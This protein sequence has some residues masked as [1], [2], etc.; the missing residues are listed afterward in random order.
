MVDRERVGVLERA[1]AVVGTE[2]SPE[3]ARLLATLA[4][5]FSQGGD[6]E[7]RLALSDEAVGCARRI[8]DEVTL[9][10]VLLHTTEA[11]RLPSTLDQRLI[12]TE[13]LFS[14]AKR[15][16]DPVL[17][18]V[19]AVRE[20]R[21]KIEA[22]AFDQVDEALTVLDEVAHIDPYVNNQRPSLLAVLAHVRGEFHAALGLADE[23]RVATGTDPDALPI[24][25]ATT[26]QVLWDMGTLGSMASTI[27]QT[28]RANPGLTG[29]RGLLGVA[30]CQVGRIEEARDILRH[31]VETDFS[32]HPLNPLWLISISLFASL[33]IELSEPTSARKLYALLEPWR[34]RANSSVVSIN[35]LVTESLAGLAVVSGDLDIAERDVAQALEQASRVGARVSATR[36]RLTR[37]RLLAAR[38]DAAS[39]HVALDEARAAADT[40]REL[41]MDAVAHAATQLVKSLTAGTTTST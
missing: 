30:Y 3:R 18:G 12:D 38:G 32:E 23:A 16:G 11:T 28:L 37:A 27:E 14:I 29:F 24:Y 41:G 13:E 7:R 17:L 1:I 22:A 36:T 6:W 8:G 5:E 26:A 34:G 33:S 21:V 10:R 4:L 31:E 39:V 25:A 9:L 2:D 40:A 19:A 35:G 15:L 20:V